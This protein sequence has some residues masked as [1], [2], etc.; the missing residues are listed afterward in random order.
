MRGVN[1]WI[2]FSTDNL[3]ELLCGV[4]RETFT[5]KFSRQD[6]I[7]AGIRAPLIDEM[8]VGWGGVKPVALKEELEE[9]ISLVVD[10]WE[11]RGVCIEQN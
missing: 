6:D 8:V 3:M 10:S 11:Y 7:N 9:E 2:F 1:K 5:C 4:I